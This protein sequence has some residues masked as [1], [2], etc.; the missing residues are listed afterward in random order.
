VLEYVLV[1]VLVLLNAA[2]AGTEMALVSLR[3]HQL[4]RMEEESE[5]GRLVAELARDPNRFLSTIQVGITLAG[6]LASAAAAVSLSAPL[7]TALEPALGGAAEPVAVLAVTIVLAYLTLVLGE[8]APKRI[9]MQRA[10]RWAMFAVRP[11][12]AMSV[13]SR[14]IIWLLGVSTN[15]V[16]RIFGVD[17]NQRSAD[18]LTAE[19]V[20]VLLTT[21]SPFSAPQQRLIEEV[22]ELGD[23]TLREILVPR[24]DVVSV[25]ADVPA[26]EALDL[27]VADGRSRAPVIE[28]D[29]DSILGVV[30]LRDL[31]KA[32]GLVRGV[33]RPAQVYPETARVLDVLRALQTDRQVMAI[34]VNEH[35]GTEGI[36][37]LEDMLEE[38]V[39]ELYDEADRDV[40]GVQVDAEGC[41][42]V[43]GSFPVHDLPDIGVEVPEGS[44]ATVAGLILEQTGE[45]PEE[46]GVEVEVDGWRFE[47]LAVDKRAITE[48]RVRQAEAGETEPQQGAEGGDAEAP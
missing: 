37:T 40:Q 42:L 31:I 43:P 28:G 36:V 16:V 32:E 10:E 17:P 9:A 23:R 22:I 45:I 3:D 44:Y 15:L 48:V 11:L 39:G 7:V 4:R 41:L 20:K 47:V 12:N 13:A 19:E 5:K 38:V 26:A 25:Q 1:F 24:R 21:E 8:L 2:F 6:F 30:H 35:G 27:L 18:D 34:V 46:P 29:L 14:P 33:A